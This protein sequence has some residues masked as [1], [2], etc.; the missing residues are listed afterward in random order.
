MAKDMTSNVFRI[1]ANYAV[2]SPLIPLSSVGAANLNSCIGSCVQWSDCFLAAFN[3]SNN[4]C[5]LYSSSVVL[6]NSSSA[7]YSTI[8]QRQIS[9]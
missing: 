6:T 2:S 3:S 8:Y 9:G 5:S 4:V 7:Q 1:L